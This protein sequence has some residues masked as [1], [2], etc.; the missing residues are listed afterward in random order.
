MVGLK[1]VFWDVDGTLAETEMYGHRIAFNSAFY[2]EKLDWSWD[3]D[4]YTKLLSVQ[5]GFN[6]IKSYSAFVGNNLNTETIKRI[7]DRKQ[8]HYQKQLKEG[9]I[10]L[11]TGVLR[12]LREIKYKGLRQWIVTTSGRKAL[13]SLILNLFKNNNNFFDGAVTYEDVNN[14]KPH[15]EAYIKAINLTGLS[16]DQ[17]IVIEDSI[18]GLTAAKEA[19][20]HCLLTLPPWNNQFKNPMQKADAVLNHLG[21]SNKSSYV[22]SGPSCTEGKVTLEYLNRIVSTT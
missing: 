13:D 17:I 12:L 18:A 1:A 14:H 5:G 19:S 10:K 11:R 6:R 15:P 7:H 4:I 3:K 2:E 22:L 21:D 8:I 20:L 16:P 9:N